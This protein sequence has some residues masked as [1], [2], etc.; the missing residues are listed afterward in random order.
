[1]STILETHLPLSSSV[2]VEFYKNKA[3]TKFIVDL[4]ASVK[5]LRSEVAALR[6]IANLKME[7]VD[8]VCEEISVSMI[9]NFAVSRD[10]V[11]IEPFTKILANILYFCKYQDVLYP[12]LLDRFGY[13]KIVEYVQTHTQSILVQTAFLNALP[14][15]VTTAYEAGEEDDFSSNPLVKAVDEKVY[16]DI[17]MNLFNL[18]TLDFFLIQYLE[19]SP[20]LDRQL[21]FKTHFTTPMYQGQSLFYWFA[22]KENYYFALAQRIAVGLLNAPTRLELVEMAKTLLEGIGDQVELASI[23]HLIQE[24][25]G[26]YNFV[27]M[28]RKDIAQKNKADR[29][30]KKK[31]KRELST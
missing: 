21:F 13:D 30:T 25:G 27:G 6:Y 2:M 31:Q 11:R 20:P 7:C 16:P 9:H 8:V 1:M 19:K 10:R 12:E 18:F 3:T 28:T 14:L 15:F 5:T 23:E 22:V 24:N 4:D 29:K 26:L 17:S